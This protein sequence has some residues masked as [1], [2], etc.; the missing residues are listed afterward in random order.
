MTGSRSGWSQV[1]RSGATPV[2]QQEGA[3]V[4]LQVDALA[5]DGPGLKNLDPDTTLIRDGPSVGGLNVLLSPPDSDRLP[6]ARGIALRKIE[7]RRAN[8]EPG[9]GVVDLLPGHWPLSGGP[10]PPEAAADHMDIG[11]SPRV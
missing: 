2:R 1:R 7:H 5:W 4:D 10:T 8:R 9:R 3:S 11:C 6:L